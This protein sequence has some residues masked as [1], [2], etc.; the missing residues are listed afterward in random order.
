MKKRK[1]FSPFL[2]VVLALLLGSA[3]WAWSVW[4]RVHEKQPDLPGNGSSETELEETDNSDITNILVL[5]IDQIKNEPARADSI[6]VLSINHKSGKVSLVSILRDARV[7][8]P[9]RGMDKINHAMAYRGEIN[10]MIKTV[11]K[12]IGVPIDHYIYTNFRGFAG[13]VDTL[14]GVTIEVEK[15]MIHPEPDEFPFHL[16]PGVQKLTGQEALGYV[17]FRNDDGGDFSRVQR[18]QKFMKALAEQVLRPATL[19]KLPSLMEQA[20]R[21]LRTD[22]TIPQLVSLG[23]LAFETDMDDVIMVALKG[24][25]ANINGTSYVILDEEHLEETIRDYIRWETSD[26]EVTMNQ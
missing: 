25:T 24:R 10:L 23:R 8:I 7:E 22:L 2:A 11:E 26:P 19:L 12:L 17:R 9:G 6:M 3:G 16:K 13:I 1:K 5:G 18:Q 14:G 20:A 15:E 4:V 21:Y